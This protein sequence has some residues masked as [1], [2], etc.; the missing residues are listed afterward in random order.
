MV[1]WNSREAI[2]HQVVILSV[3][4][5][6]KRA[7]ARSL[8]ISRNR[9]KRIIEA[10]EEKRLSQPG[11][12]GSDARERRPSK[13]DRHRGEVERL[14]KEF[15][16]ITAQRVFEELKAQGY[17]GGYSI[18]KTLVRDLRPRAPAKISLPTPIYGPGEMSE[19][20]WS[21]YWI[22]FTHEPPRKIH[23]FGY[24]LVYSRR[25]C[26]SLHERQDTQALLNGHIEAFTRIGGVA[27]QSKYDN[28]KSVVLRWEGQQPIYNPR[29][30]DFATYY[31]FMPRACR[32]YHPNDKPRVERSF[33]EFERS[34]LNGRKFRDLNDMKAQLVQWMDEV[35]DM[36]RHR[37]TRMTPL[38]RFA[39]E[40]PHLQ[41]LPAHS[42]D[43]ARVVYRVCDAEGCVAFEGNRYE[44]PYQYV[45]E[46][47]PVRITATELFVYAADLTCIAN[48]PR[49]RKGAGERAELPG[50][51]I[52]AQRPRGPTLEQLR[53]V[54]R[55]M[56]LDA[57][58]FLSKLDKAQR[59][60]AYHA[61]KILA[62]RE[63][64][65]TDDLVA[66]LTH[67]C[68]YQAFEHRAIE[69]ILISRAKPRKFDEYI[70][71]AT[72]SKLESVLEHN[73]TEPRPLT[74]YDALVR[75]ATETGEPCHESEEATEPPKTSKISTTLSPAC[76]KPS[77]S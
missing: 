53:P 64:Y 49:L 48:H 15:P 3:Q 44:V 63:R 24:T 40:Q 1:P 4:G 8:K 65:G 61:R 41:P 39:E 30:I 43:T 42:Y 38:E 19:C 28:M 51:A 45:T 13:L 75:A 47:L 37:Q 14:L 32:P 73:C 33:W 46:I 76:S 20:D 6:S 26:F 67:A 77:G 12:I 11:A 5:M 22:P 29:F 58:I 25:K 35:S 18:V 69:R 34:F 59:N 72:A 54:F 16:D 27:S 50:R 52:P 70:A 62:L 60:A 23:A 2:E 21:E 7:I 56:G 36:R 31:R 71:E 10:H 9:V 55:E 74:D 57:D 17:E 66:A 68:K